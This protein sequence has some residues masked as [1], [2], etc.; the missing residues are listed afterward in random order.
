MSGIFGL[1]PLDEFPVDGPAFDQQLVHAESGCAITADARID[2]RAGDDRSAAE[3]ILEAYLE[4]G[5]NCLD[6]L[7]GDFAFAIWDPREQKFFCA[8]DHFGMRPFYYHHAPGKRFVFASSAREMFRVAEVPY[9]INRE[10]VADYIVP[11]LEWIDYTSTFFEGICRVPPGHKL[12]ITPGSIELL[13]FWNPT[14]GPSLPTM[15][16]EDYIEGFLAVFTNAVDERLREPQGKVGA[17]L[18]GGM[19]SGSVAAIVNELL[20]TRGEGPLRTISAARKPVVNCD[21]SQRIYAIVKKLGTKSA[22]VDPDDIA[23]LDERL[24]ADLDEPFDG[25]F[26]FMKAIFLAAREQGLDALLDGGAGDLLFNEGAYITRLLRRGRIVSAYREILAASTFWGGQ[27]VSSELLRAPLRAAL[28]EPLKRIVRPR[29]LRARARHFVAD[30]LIS[31][32]L[33]NEVD[34]EARCERM[35]QMFPGDWI[36]DPALERVSKIRPNVSAGRERYARLA[37]SAGVDTRDPF[38]DLYV[39]AYCSQLPGHM[40]LRNGWPKYLLRAAMAGKLPETV[41][42]GRGKPHLGWAFSDAFLRRQV[43]GGTITLNSLGASLDGYVDMA[44]L[45]DLWRQF[46]SGGDFERLYSA[47]ILARWLC[48]NETRPVVK[49]R[50]F[51]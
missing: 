6:G 12:V 19:D 18:S 31:E 47:M 5:E 14:P 49:H 1:L 42:W 4:R 37:A 16:D 28:P 9:S 3:I 36:A 25:E 41:R 32:S 21:E 34:I 7:L 51:S 44:K 38:L 50:G 26:L 46:E 39:V 11:E 13:E 20:A 29:R 8:R 23:P 45:N 27:R 33:A 15:S 30:S 2:Y 17:M 43:E 40:V 10:R 24:I 35:W 22:I 48:A